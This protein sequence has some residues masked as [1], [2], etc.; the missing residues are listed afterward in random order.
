MVVPD[1]VGLLAIL[2]GGEREIV[3][4]LR[5][6][7]LFGQRPIERLAGF[8]GDHASG[9]GDQ[10][11]AVGGPAQRLFAK[12]AQRL[13]IGVSGVRIAAEAHVNRRDHRPTLAIVGFGG[14]PRLDRRHGRLDPAIRLWRDLTARQ[15]LV[16]QHGLADAPVEGKGDRRQSDGDQHSR[17]ETRAPRWQRRLGGLGRRGDEA[18]RGL[19]PGALRFPLRQESALDV[20]PYFLELRLIERRFVRRRVRCRVSRRAKQ[21]PKRGQDHASRHSRQNEPHHQRASARPLS[22]R[23]EKSGLCY[24][25]AKFRSRQ[26]RRSAANP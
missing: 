25:K 20:A 7:R 9:G 15:R 22:G 8:V 13:G 24:R 5:L 1:R 10:G 16:G 19:G 26:N 23:G 11:L 14:E 21:R 2:L 17:C 6:A 3:A 18:A 12:N 4:R